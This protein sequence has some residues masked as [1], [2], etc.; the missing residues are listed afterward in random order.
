MYL[1]NKYWNFNNFFENK[2][3]KFY[4]SNRFVTQFLSSL[5]YQVFLKGQ[6]IVNRGENFENLY[7]IE[8]GEV[9]VRDHQKGELIAKIPKY[10]FFGDYQ[11]LLNIISN[12]WFTSGLTEKVICYTISKQRFIELWNESK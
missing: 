8:K 3:L 9:L 12:V 6:V 7:L 10:G 1:L 4:S 5:E 2:A 11:I